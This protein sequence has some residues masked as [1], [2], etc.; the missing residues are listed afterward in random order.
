VV[1][2]RTTTVTHPVILRSA[3]RVHLCVLL[4]ILEQTT[5]PDSYSVDGWVFKTETECVYCTVR[6]GSINK[7]Y[8]VFTLKG[9]FVKLLTWIWQMVGSS[10]GRD[11]TTFFFVGFLSPSR[12]NGKR[13]K[14]GHGHFLLRLFRF[15]SHYNFITECC[16]VWVNF[17]V[18][19]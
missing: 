16:I 4:W 1:I 15:N 14:L 13:V 19:K 3:D 10:V 2:L 11:K 12:N 6:T 8:Y 7:I 9:Y 18:V 17:R 5:T